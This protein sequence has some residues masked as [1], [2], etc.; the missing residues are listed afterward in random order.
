VVIW[1]SDGYVGNDW[2][3][4]LGIP[5]FWCISSGGQVPGHIPHAQLPARR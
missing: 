5:A 2:A 3:E 4:D 1:L